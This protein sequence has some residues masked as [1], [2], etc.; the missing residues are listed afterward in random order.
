MKRKLLVVLM[1]L[2]MSLSLT[3]T[4]VD[5]ENHIASQDVEFEWH[6]IEDPETNS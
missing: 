3:F 2:V 6:S 4:Y 1:L 5:T